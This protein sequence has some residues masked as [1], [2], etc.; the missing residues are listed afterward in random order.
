MSR[1]S[2]L[3]IFAIACILL[4]IAPLNVYAESKA[5]DFDVLYASRTKEIITV[6]L[7]EKTL[8]SDGSFSVNV[9]LEAN[10]SLTYGMLLYAEN[11][12]ITG[13]GIEKLLRARSAS[14]PIVGKAPL[15]IGKVTFSPGTR[16]K[17][18]FGKF[19]LVKGDEVVMGLFD[20]C[21]AITLFTGVGY[22]PTKWP[23]LGRQSIE[24]LLGAL[25]N[26]GFNATAFTLALQ[27]DD[28]IGALRVF[29]DMV[30][31]HPQI[32]VDFFAKEYGLSIDSL[33]LSKFGKNAGRGLAVISALEVIRDLFARP[34]QGEVEISAVNVSKENSVDVV[35]VIDRSFS[36]DGQKLADAKEAAKQFIDLT[37]DGDGIG[38]VSFAGSG[39]VHYELASSS[40]KTRNEASLAVESINLAAATS[41]GAGLSLGQ[42]QL[43]S[44][45]K[46]NRNR[47]I[48]LL[49]DGEENSAPYVKDVLPSVVDA[50][51]RTYTV[52]LGNDAD[53]N[54]MQDIATQTKGF[55][56]FAPDSTALRSLY[57]RIS[58]QVIGHETVVAGKGEV[59]FGAVESTKA[60]ISSR[61]ATFS[62]NW[63]DSNAVLNLALISPSGRRVDSGNFSTDS[64]IS[65]VGGPNYQYY[66]LLAP[67]S[68]VWTMETSALKAGLVVQG[69]E[70]TSI[71]YDYLATVGS[72][73]KLNAYSPSFTVRQGE[74]IVMSAILYNNQGGVPDASVSVS[75]LGDSG[76]F[77]L[78]DDGQHGDYQSRDGIYSG[79]FN[80]ALSPGAHRFRVHATGSDFSRQS[81]V[82]ILVSNS[83][84]PT[85][86]LW[87][88]ASHTDF[89]SPSSI[90][91]FDGVLSNNGPNTG[92]ELQL[93]VLLPADLDFIS[94]SLGEPSSTSGRLLRW[95]IPMPSPY[96]SKSFSIRT[97]VGLRAPIGNTLAA[98]FAVK[99]DNNSSDSVSGNNSVTTSFD[100]EPR[101]SL[102]LPSLR[103]VLID[104]ETLNNSDG[105][106]VYSS[107]WG[108]STKRGFGNFQD[109]VHYTATDGMFFEYTFDGSGISIASESDPNYGTADVY[110]DGV[111]V[112]TVSAVGPEHNKAE[113]TLYSTRTLPR[114]RHTI[115]VVK[116]SGAYLVLD[117]LTVYR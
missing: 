40:A 63:S 43:T 77:V 96:A 4:S 58:T 32:F 94:S 107:F 29:S 116:R 117:A 75:L 6:K 112:A 66:R 71:T 25:N 104:G 39:F 67:E 105:R 90:V 99:T 98:Q 84:R 3:L 106:I 97:R 5:V 95:Q 8:N 47:A 108:H 92:K 11:G 49:T 20:L 74:P 31:R 2:L 113:Y 34:S 18:K 52:G 114:G 83:L 19:G 30:T 64:S 57:N 102:H 13:E 111:K 61:D 87:L 36:M 115:K 12:S 68:G 7:S 91:R 9:T 70:Q 23:D 53:H 56:V 22:L 79:V 44:R 50:A 37:R 81:D 33:S 101:Y 76:T 72:E 110:I 73:L 86:D 16:L 65:F 27:R 1:F 100:I 24:G 103:S 85:T 46:A 88:T 28:Y 42:Q 82:T 14:I 78:F 69:L 62:I 109:D 93:E 59:S 48:V 35:L 21:T 17:I 38:I 15:E 80:G 55:Y 54:L 60:V 89:A 26:A 51:T 10:S 41:I 45:G